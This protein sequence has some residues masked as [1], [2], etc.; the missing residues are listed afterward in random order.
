MDPG[1]NVVSSFSAEKKKKV[2]LTPSLLFTRHLCATDPSRFGVGNG[3]VGPGDEE[4]VVGPPDCAA[5]AYPLW[6]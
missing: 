4:W 3:A 2:G 5:V 6:V 1:P